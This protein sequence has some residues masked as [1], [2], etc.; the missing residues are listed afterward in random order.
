LNSSIFREY[1]IRG[2]ADLDLKDEVV[3]DIGLAIGTMFKQEGVKTVS[4]GRDCRVSSDRIFDIFSNSLIRTGINIIDLGMVT[5]PVLYFSLYGLDVDG[6]VMITASHNPSDYN[7]FKAA[8]GKDVLSAGQIQNI[9]EIIKNKNYSYS[10]ENGV[11]NKFN[12]IDLYKEDILKSINLKKKVSVGVD[13][14]NTPIGIFA[15]DIMSAAGCDVHELF[16]EPD[17]SFPNHHPDPSVEENLKDL[18]AL[19]KEKNLDFGVSFDGDADR[20]GVIDENGNFI[21]SD[22]V[23]L[24]LAR[25]VLKDNPGSK[26][27]GEVKCSKNLFEDIAKNGGVPIMW[28]TGHSNIKRKVKE[29]FSPLAG[30]LSGH[31]FFADKHHGFDDALYAAL[32]IAE[33]LSIQDGTFSSMLKDIPKMYSTPEMRI[34]FPEEEK[35]KFIEDFSKSMHQTNDSS[36]KLVTVDGIR[37]ETNNGWALVRASNTQPALTIRF[38]ANSEDSLNKLINY[39]QDEINK[40][41]DKICVS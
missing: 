8:I 19:V 9:K 34:D 30:E 22:M 2:I 25:S 5:T 38:E 33:V 13:C 32:R 39:V 18:V 1:D 21:Y 26:I 28:R 23:L 11:I 29:E 27:I 17:G 35:F 40:V 6:G 3:T 31:I 36:I 15:K 37:I 24:L 16:P 12:L 14:A 4:L 7:G 10:Q 20:I 41:T